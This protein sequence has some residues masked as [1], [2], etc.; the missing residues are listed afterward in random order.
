VNRVNEV[1]KGVGP[2]LAQRDTDKSRF[3]EEARLAPEEP[4][5]EDMTVF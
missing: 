3:Y 4:E 1:N 2:G 5:Y